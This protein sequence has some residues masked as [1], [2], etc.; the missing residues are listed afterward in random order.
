MGAASKHVQDV[1]RGSIKAIQ[2]FE[3]YILSEALT[4][5]A[6]ERWLGVDQ[7]A[8]MA[9]LNSAK[10]GVAE[11]DL[12]LKIRLENPT[13]GKA[14]IAVILK[15]DYNFRFSE[16]TV[17]RILNHLKDKGKITQSIS[18][19]RSKRKRNFKKHANA[20]VYKKYEE[21]KMGEYVQI[22]HMTVTKN[23]VKMKHFQAWERKSKTLFA[24]VY[25]SAKSS[26]A[27][28]FL[29]ELVAKAPYKIKSIQ[30]DGGSE[31]MGDFEDECSKLNIPLY[32]LPPATPKYNGGVERA[33]RI[34]REE[35]YENH[36]WLANSI[37]DM[38]I[39]L[40]KML[41]KYNEYRPHAGLNGL[42]PL[43]YISAQSE[44]TSLSQSI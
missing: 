25:S 28:K 39:E 22:D 32:V 11:I 35:F 2:I 3:S 27:K 23:R 33:N 8:S 4:F 10:W 29:Q 26:D 36:G 17:G 14:K 38:R 41:R 43:E 16:S 15:R 1:V 44:T 5:E 12:V 34:L 30:V 40:Q 42:T 7:Q 24:Q 37:E 19:L 20:L 31:F 13:Y 9:R 6:V 21:M 18:A